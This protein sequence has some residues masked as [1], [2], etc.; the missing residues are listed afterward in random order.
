MALFLLRVNTRHGTEP[1][2]ELS[3]NRWGSIKSSSLSA[4]S[5]ILDDSSTVLQSRGS[6]SGVSRRL[7]ASAAARCTASH[8]LRAHALPASGVSECSKPL[9]KN[10]ARQPQ[11][12]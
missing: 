12:L 9:R 5:L 6:G 11:P 7:S 10:I 1:R 8:G 4:S 2:I 3:Y